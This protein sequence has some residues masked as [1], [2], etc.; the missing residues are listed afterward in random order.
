MLASGSIDCKMPQLR[1]LAVVVIAFTPCGAHV[2]HGWGT[3]GAL[4]LE[5]ARGRQR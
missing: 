4:A 2:G 5:F 1:V 3:G